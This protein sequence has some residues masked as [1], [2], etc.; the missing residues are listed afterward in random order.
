MLAALLRQRRRLL[1]ATVAIALSV[2]YLAGALNLLDRVGTGLDA[3]A[4][5]GSGPAELVVEGGIAYESPTEQVRRLVPAAI[6]A[7]VGD[8]AGVAAVSP[9]IEDTAPLVGPD[10]ETL[11]PLGLTEQ[12]IGA[13]FPTDPRLSP[14]EFSE[15]G[16]PT[17]AEQVAIDQRSATEGGVGIGDQV[18][19]VGRAGA[20]PYTVSGVV[21]TEGGG[22]PPGSSLALL[23]TEEARV[24]FD[25]PTDDNTVD[26]LLEP[27]ADPDEV[28]ATIGA[29]LP[30]GIEVVDRATAAEHRQESFDRS[31]TLVRSLILGFAGLAL[32]VGMVTVGNSLALLYAERRRT[33]AGLRLV[34][35]KPWQLLTAALAEAASLALVASLLG[36]PLGLLLGRLI[37][38]ALGA[39]NTSVPVAGPAISWSALAWA[40]VIGV[41]ATVVAA[42][43]PAARA[44]RVPP[45]E[46]VSH[47]AAPRPRSFLQSAARVGLVAVVLGLGAAL[48]VS[49]GEAGMDP[50]ALGAV[51]ALVVCALGLLPLVLSGLVAGAVRLLPLRPA[52]LRTIAARD[53]SRHRS[54]TAA[55]AA[56]LILATAVVSGLAVFLSS[57]AASV[58]GEVKDLVKADLVV[59]SGTFTK[60]GLPEDLVTRISDLPGVTA[61]SGWEIGRGWVG[62]RSVRMTGFDIANLDSLLA[63]RWVGDAPPALDA[64]S[65]VVSSRLADEL[66]IQ[67]GASIPI[68]FTSSGAEDLRVAGIYSSGDLLLGDLVIDR[69]VV[70]R[71]VPAT[72]DIATML[73]AGPRS[74]S[75]R[76]RRA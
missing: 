59:D 8:V 10:G 70:Q 71:Q 67:V 27:G 41:V 2:G 73:R 6:G 19:V 64:S 58:D 9:R 46:A 20:A 23:T 37:E 76:P 38:G 12:P 72:T 7:A 32:V 47:A 40:V 34:G 42:V 26:V 36:A 28:A 65:V 22:L 33:F 1:L 68:T 53:V 5:S 62:A 17:D 69:S 18:I 55:T 25:R 60:G 39:L 45:I 43:L 61:V 52:A 66:G 21:R 51:T 13:N 48:L 15:G 75:W 35:A 56:A 44:C 49:R 50:V 57:F 54:R 24:R 3:L 30:P 29:L 63:P 16:P 31:F 74:R 11:V 4:A 14:Y